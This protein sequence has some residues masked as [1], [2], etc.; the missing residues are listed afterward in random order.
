MRRWPA[1]DEVRAAL[2]A[3]RDDLIGE[4]RGDRDGT[5][6]QV[7]GPF[8]GYGRTVTDE[9]DHLVERTTYRLLLPW[10]GWLFALPVRWAIA[11]RGRPPAAPAGAGQRAQRTPWWSPPDRLTQRQLTVLGLLAASSMSSAFINTLFTQT[12][13]FAADDFGVGDTG[14]GIAGSLVRAGIVIALPAAVLADRIGRRRV[15]VAMSF[16]APLIS[17]AGALA[18]N[19]PFLV[20]TQTIGRPLGLAL[21]FMV[22][23]VAAE[24]MPRNSRAYAVSILAMASGLGSGVA[25]IAL[26]LADTSESGWR[27][28]YV[29]TLIWLVVAVDMLRRLPETERFARPH[30][31][32]SRLD[33]RRFGV[34]AAIALLTN[35]LVAPASFFQNDYLKDE[36]GYSATIIA[37]FTLAT[38]TPAALGLIAGGRLADT[39]GRRRV[40]ATGLP[41][42]AVL[43]TVSFSIGGPVMWI[44]TVL[45]GMAGAVAYP[46]LAVYRAELFPTGN[47]GRAAGMLT[48]AALL[49]GI[50]GLLLMGQLLDRGT[51]HGAV[52]GGLAVG[53]LAAVAVALRWL[54]ETAHRELEDLNPEDRPAAV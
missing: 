37:I 52:I 4:A 12:V 50:G 19:F 7:D 35:L 28:V 25:V 5:F 9:G 38:A 32:A 34:L 48:T 42:A 13:T 27:L 40:V 29:V 17:A 44:A 20:A 11:R 8:D 31:V 51:S 21:D 18:P 33:R 23:V 49:G 1:T 45:A 14:I 15:I 26:P 43:I 24:E 41:V 6:V 47:R 39:G 53:Q 10:F 54:P 46:A 22:A 36:R 16:A 3:P 2:A 30:V